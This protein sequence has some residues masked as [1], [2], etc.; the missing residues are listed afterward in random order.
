MTRKS[1]ICSEIYQQNAACLLE[2]IEGEEVETCKDCK[3]YRVK[4]A[5]TAN[6]GASPEFI[7]EIP[8]RQ[9][10]NDRTTVLEIFNCKN[11]SESSW[12]VTVLSKSNPKHILHRS[13][14]TLRNPLFILIFT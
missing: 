14:L 4:V 11:V 6:D 12:I 2:T 10:F 7:A 13:F 1:E 9:H 3:H 5:E 8:I